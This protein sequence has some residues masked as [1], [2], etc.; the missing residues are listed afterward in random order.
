MNTKVIVTADDLGNVINSSLNDQIGYISIQQNTNSISSNWIK[1]QKRSCLIFGKIEDLQK[2]DF[3]AGQELDGKIIV[4]ESF[5]PFNSN[6]SERELKIAGDTGVV[7][8][9]DDQ[10]IYRRT[11]YTT[12]PDEQDVLIQ[13]NNSEE[14][15]ESVNAMKLVTTDL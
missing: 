4:E 14:I 10:P 13:H 1:Q 9:V 3:K 8:R 6:N 2:F 11:R 7:C 12:N 5:V 15:R